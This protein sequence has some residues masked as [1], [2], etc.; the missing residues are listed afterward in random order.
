MSQSVVEYKNRKAYFKYEIIDNYIA[1]IQLLGTEVKSIRSGK[2]NFTDAY[3][4]IRNGEIFIHG[5]HIAEYAMGTCNNHTPTR[6]RKLL[7]NK[8]EIIKIEKKINEKGLTVVPLKVFINE[9]GLVKLEIAVAKGKKIYD[10][11]E[12]IKEKDAK[13]ESNRLSKYS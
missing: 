4:I 1:G 2:V 10:K 9:K 8:K 11:R 12:S 3:C 7:L 6:D 13:R 5:L